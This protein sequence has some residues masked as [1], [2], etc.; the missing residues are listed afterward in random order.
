MQRREVFVAMLLACVG[1]L[2][3]VIY[4]GD[5]LALMGRSPAP[6]VMLSQPAAS[7]AP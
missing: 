6:N 4:R 7:V 1:T 5:F 2:G 3:F